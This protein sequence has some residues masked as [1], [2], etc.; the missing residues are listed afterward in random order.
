M[1][2]PSIVPGDRVVDLAASLRFAALVSGGISCAVSLW[3]IK[4]SVLWSAVALVVGAVAG[5]CIGLVLGPL[6]FPASAGDV[7]VVK[8]GSGSLVATLKA[9][10]FGAVIAGAIAAAVP[11][12]IFG[13]TSKLAMLIGVGCA[14]G[15][16][17]GGVLGYLASQ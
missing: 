6:I 11:A 1:A 3:V 14:V 10:L 4:Q 9:G 8:V 17:I 2:D 5:L 15:V 12:G 16:V 7:A 13:Q